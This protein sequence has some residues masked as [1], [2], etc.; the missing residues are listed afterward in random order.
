TELLLPTQGPLPMSAQTQTQR[1]AMDSATDSGSPAARPPARRRS[2]G[3]PMRDSTLRKILLYIALA[4]AGGTF[5][6]PIYWVFSSAVKTNSGIYQYPPDWFPWPLVL[7]NF[8]EA[9]RA[10]PFNNFLVNS[11]IVTAVGASLKLMNA[12]FTAYAFT[13]LRFPL[14]NVLFL[15][16]LGSLMVPNNVTLIVNYIP[17]AN[18]HWINT[19]TGLILPSSGSIFGMF[20]L[21]QYMMTLPKEINEAAKVDGAGHFRMLFQVVLPMCKPM[22]VTVGVIA[23][24]DMWNDFIWPLIVTNT[25]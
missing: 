13:H 8:G 20:L 9:W 25:V 14:K 24:V 16:M 21:R 18:L 5:I 15:F 6:I 23:V 22:L 10:A 19:C 3:G 2:R 1:G 17:I 4:V 12:T 11:L 7:E